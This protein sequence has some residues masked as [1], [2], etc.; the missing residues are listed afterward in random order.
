MTIVLAIATINDAQEIYDLQIKSFKAL[1][2]KH[3]DFN[4]SPGAE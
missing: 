4:F 2:E 3:H 1:L